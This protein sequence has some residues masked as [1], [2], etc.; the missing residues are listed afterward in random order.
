MRGTR[1][2]L[3]S[4]ASMNKNCE[5]FLLVALLV[6]S[7]P[8]LAR[9]QQQSS[10]STQNGEPAVSYGSRAIRHETVATPSGEGSSQYIQGAAGSVARPIASKL[11]DVV[12]VKDFGAKGDGA[13]DDT[14]AI[15]AAVSSGAKSVFVPDGTYEVGSI[16]MP[17]TSGFVLDGSGSSA[18]LAEKP[19]A[20]G[21]M[22]RWSSGSTVYSQQTIKNIALVGTNG[23][24]NLIDTTGTGG[25][26]ILN[27]YVIDVPAGKSAFYINGA[28]NYVHDMRLINVQVYSNTAGHSAIR[29]GPLA[30]DS[31]VDEFIF[32]GNFLTS[33]G[34]YADSGAQTVT[35][36]N[37]HIYNAARN[38]LELAGENASWRF[39]NDTFDNARSDLVTILNSKQITFANS[40][41]EAIPSGF[42][43]IKIE[44]ISSEIDIAGSIFSGS[45]RAMSAV[46]AGPSTSSIRIQGGS[47][48]GAFA[49]PFGLGGTLS[50][51]RGVLGHDPL[52]LQW[53]KTGV[54]ASPQAQGTTLYLGEGSSASE[55]N[56]VY[57]VP[58]SGTCNIVHIAV[59]ATPAPGQTFTFQIRK[60]GVGVGTR[61]V[62]HHG[63]FSGTIALGQSFSQY[64]QFAISSTFSAN[65][66]SATVRY[67]ADFN[68]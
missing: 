65:S 41:F 5:G 2:S 28:A 60:N 14:A 7:G 8:L 25:L 24:Q 63:Q 37:S 59:S 45:S 19:G 39:W 53:P 27:V 29:F 20:A 42:S 48:A 46:V 43:G 54:E 16:Q 68:G 26:T 1:R 33:Y 61:L 67:A 32:N 55:A 34:L 15:Q 44:G 51:T 57:T 47:I 30:S 49:M 18:K 21:A 4:G 12:S 66:G 62:I 40:Y 64:D 50:W 35:V 36:A 52:G 31:S 56:A 9:T 3:V 58:Y 22:I 11:A 17:S 13:S 10:V 6:V 38:I 23:S